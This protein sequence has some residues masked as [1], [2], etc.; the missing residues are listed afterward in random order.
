MWANPVAASLH[1]V[2][3]KIP[4]NA[5]RSAK[6][7]K[8]NEQ[9]TKEPSVY[10]TPHRPT[11]RDRAASSQDG[12]RE[13]T[14]AASAGVVVTSVMLKSSYNFLYGL[15]QSKHRLHNGLYCLSVSPAA[16]TRLSA[17]NTLHVKYEPICQYKS[18]KTGSVFT[19]KDTN[20][21]PVS[22]RLKMTQWVVKRKQ[23][24][25]NIEIMSL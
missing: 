21:N 17:M 5:T 6:A 16:P 9:N 10:V 25:S 18:R 1:G 13:E 24:Q 15:S 19:D 8:L 22:M 14:K 23:I 3:A 4:A 12:S 7:E 20:R 2:G 11:G